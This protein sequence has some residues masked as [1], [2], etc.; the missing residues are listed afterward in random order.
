MPIDPSGTTPGLMPAGDKPKTVAIRCK[1]NGCDS[2]EAVEMPMPGNSG[3]RLYRCA[4]CHQAH[5][6]QTGGTFEI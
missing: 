3:A 1:R 6:V 5:G 4:K 2:I